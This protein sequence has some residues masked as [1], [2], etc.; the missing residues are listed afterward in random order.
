MSWIYSLCFSYSLDWPF[1]KFIKLVNTENCSK[2]WA[3]DQSFW[4]VLSFFSTFLWLNNGLQFTSFPII[5]HQFDAVLPKYLR[6][7]NE[8]NRSSLIPTWYFGKFNAFYIWSTAMGGSWGSALKARRKSVWLLMVSLEFFI[9]IILPVTL[10]PWGDL[11]SNRNGYQEYFLGIKGGQCVG[12]TTLPSS[13]ADWKSWGL[14][15]LEASEPV[16]TCR[17]DCSTFIC[18]LAP[19][20]HTHTHT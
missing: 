11:A 19:Y 12:L 13:C 8:M 7:Q 14:K 2:F 18:G 10:W 17:G 16:Q 3:L 1:F 20:F 6:D 4:Q 5:N 15:L 9:H